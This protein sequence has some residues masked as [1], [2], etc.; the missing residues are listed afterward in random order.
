[1]RSDDFFNADT[2]PKIIFESTSFDGKKLKGHLTIRNITKE[3]ELDVEYNGTAVDPY[4]Q[5][6]AGFEISGAIHRKDFGLKWDAVTEAG[7]VVVSDKVRLAI[8]AQFIKQ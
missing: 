4:G 8:H 2:Y 7:S 5:T 6:K 1:L 3:I